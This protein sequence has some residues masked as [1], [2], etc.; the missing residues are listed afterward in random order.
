VS[1]IHFAYLVL[2]ACLQFNNMLARVW[3]RGEERFCGTWLCFQCTTVSLSLILALAIHAGSNIVRVSDRR[4][5][6]RRC[7]I[8]L[9]AAL[10]GFI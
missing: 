6:K 10:T 3:R 2:A 4:F 9:F 1:P 8:R 5:D 7:F